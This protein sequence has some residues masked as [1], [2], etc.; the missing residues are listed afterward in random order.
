MP[1]VT[2]SSS[3]RQQNI[4][5]T[6]TNN[7]L[8]LPLTTPNVPTVPVPPMA[9]KAPLKKLSHELDLESEPES[10]PES[11]LGYCC[12]CCDDIACEKGRFVLDCGHTFH[13]NCILRSF[14]H[15]NRCPMC[16]VQVDAADKNLDYLF[17]TALRINSSIISAAADHFIQ[18][19]GSITVANVIHRMLLMSSDNPDMRSIQIPY[20]KRILVQF[21]TMFV[22]GIAFSVRDGERDIQEP[23]PIDVINNE[24]PLRTE[25]EYDAAISNPAID[26]AVS[27]ESII[28]ADMNFDAV[29]QPDNVG[30]IL[31]RRAIALSELGSQRADLGNR[32]A[33][34]ADNRRQQMLMVQ[35]H[36]RTEMLRR[37]AIAEQ[38]NANGQENSD[39]ETVIME[40]QQDQNPWGPQF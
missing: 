8:N 22:T 37:Q 26:A 15:D 24:D 16:R 6:N 1:A 9:P 21:A 31:L 38:Q 33:A 30:A 20:I 2:R 32:R 14:K 19:M 4:T 5:N 39:D 10:E 36:L 23:V 3:N 28:S 27:Y 29:S 7:P 17:P 12:I 11:K 25:D 34:R 40:S 18:D 35:Q 13:G